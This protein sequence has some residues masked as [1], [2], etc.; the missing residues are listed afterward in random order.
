M[1]PGKSISLNPIVISDFWYFEHWNIPIFKVERPQ[2]K[3]YGLSFLFLWISER[4]Y[5]WGSFQLCWVSD[6]RCE[7]L[8]NK[9]LRNK[10]WNR[11]FFDDLHNFL[12]IL[13]TIFRVHLCRLRI[14][15][16]IWIWFVQ[17]RLNRRLNIGKLPTVRNNISYITH[18]LYNLSQMTRMDGRSSFDKLTNIALAS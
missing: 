10:V 11:P 2:Y 1:F 18:D 8:W 17:Q 7:L 12:F 9:I 14:C 15:W 13:A 5:H 6:L 16:R 4:K 3:N